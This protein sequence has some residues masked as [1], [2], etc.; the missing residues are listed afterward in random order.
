MEKTKHENNSLIYEKTVDKR[1][2]NQLIYTILF[3]CIGISLLTTLILMIPKV[4]PFFYDSAFIDHNGDNFFY[5]WFYDYYD[6]GSFHRFE[7]NNILPHYGFYIFLPLISISFL[8][9]GFC[10]LK[11]NPEQ[12][13]LTIFI[14]WILGLAPIIAYIIIAHQ[15]NA[16][17]YYLN[18]NQ[19]YFLPALGLYTIYS[20]LPIQLILISTKYKFTEF[21][22]IYK[23]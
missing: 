3:Y 9:A 6:G 23:E 1:T 8:L 11:S 21:I 7:L 16:E 10:V 2:N 5:K 4:D 17:F 13:R 14:S 15:I 19:Q 20:M 12:K 22:G 18:N